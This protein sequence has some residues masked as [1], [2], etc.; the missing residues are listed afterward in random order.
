MSSPANT[1]I[2]SQPRD[3]VVKDKKPTNTTL[4]ERNPLVGKHE[5]HIK[6]KRDNVID[7]ICNPTTLCL[8]CQKCVCVEEECN[9][10]PFRTEGSLLAKLNP[11]CPNPI[12]EK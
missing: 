7:A 11:F 1:S 3:T 2:Y 10:V 5:H 8:S 12:A 9:D 4:K 6:T